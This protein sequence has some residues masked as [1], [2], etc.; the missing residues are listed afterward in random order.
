MADKKSEDDNLDEF[1][2]DFADL[3]TSKDVAVEDV[4]EAEVTAKPA[5]KPAAK[6]AAPKKPVAKT[7][8]IML[9]DSDFIPPT[10]LYVGHNGRGYMIRVGEPVDV[11]QHILEI[12]D[13]AVIS[14]PQVDPQTRRV[15]GYRDRMRYPYRRL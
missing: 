15:I 7:T 9:E 4:T 5:A 2:K 14:Q 1:E 8:K 12:L 6:K 10:G 3:D 13:H 11:P